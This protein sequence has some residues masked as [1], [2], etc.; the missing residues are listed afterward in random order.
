[1]SPSSSASPMRLPTPPLA[2]RLPS[3][4]ARLNR[5]AAPANKSHSCLV[6]HPDEEPVYQGWQLPLPDGVLGVLSH[7]LQYDR[8]QSS[9]I[10]A[11]QV[12]HAQRRRPPGDDTM[13]EEWKKSWRAFQKWIDQKSRWQVPSFLRDAFLAKPFL[14]VMWIL[15]VSASRG[16][17]G[18][19]SI[20]EHKEIA[21]WRNSAC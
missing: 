3:A 18:P 17:N 4:Q 6:K 10:Y 8:T 16:S 19:I 21:S 1:M 9:L 2:P 12:L 11:E 13:P 20:A 7:G 14:G 5:A 15:A